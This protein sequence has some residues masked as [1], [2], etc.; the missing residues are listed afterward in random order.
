MPLYF[1]MM[2][3]PT[4]TRPELKATVDLFMKLA[5]DNPRAFV[6]ANVYAPFPG[7]ELFDL[8]VSEGLKPPTRMEDWFSFSYRNLGAHGAWLPDSMRK[9]VEMLDFCAFFASERGYVTPFKQT[10]PLATAAARVYAPLARM[11]MKHLF[12]YV[13]LEIAAARKLGL[14]GNVD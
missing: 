2:G 10:H 11:R 13:P 4:E 1:F 3:F 6:S 14:Y 12:H 5:A 7:T 9:T 8:A